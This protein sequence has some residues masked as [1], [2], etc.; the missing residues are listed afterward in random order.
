MINS[1]E[2]DNLNKVL[3][4]GTATNLK[5]YA[6]NTVPAGDLRLAD[7]PPWILDTIEFKTV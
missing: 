3:Q 1:C 7:R 4:A 6:R 2:D 5:R